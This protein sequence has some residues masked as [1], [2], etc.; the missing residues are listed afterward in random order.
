MDH[1]VVVDD[2]G[3]FVR[4]AEGKAVTIQAYT[5]KSAKHQAKQR[6]GADVYVERAQ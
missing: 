5:R 6:Y 2:A 1:Y 3:V 4:D